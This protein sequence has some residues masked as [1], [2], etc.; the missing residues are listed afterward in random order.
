MGGREGDGQDE[1]LEEEPDGGEEDGQPVAAHLRRNRHRRWVAPSGGKGKEV[2]SGELF[3]FASGLGTK[4][5][6]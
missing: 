1:E 3:H 2:V 5:L 6:N 4:G